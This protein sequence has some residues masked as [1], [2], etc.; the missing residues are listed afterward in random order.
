MVHLNL[1]AKVSL[2][3]HDL[4]FGFIKFI[5]EKYFPY[6]SFSKYTKFSNN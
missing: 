2:E 3:I 1:N 5:V 4:Y 6:A